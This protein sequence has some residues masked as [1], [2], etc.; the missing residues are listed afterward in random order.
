MLHT[1]STLNWETS[2]L[3]RKRGVQDDWR[4]PVTIP[5]TANL[6]SVSNEK[7]V[8]VALPSTGW[9]FCL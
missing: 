3:G 4:G 1:I 6:S 7:V 9:L 5:A 8:G 2:A